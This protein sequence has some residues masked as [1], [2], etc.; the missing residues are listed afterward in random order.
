LRVGAIGLGVVTVI[1]DGIDQELKTQRRAPAIARHQT[2][3]ARQVAARAIPADREARRISAD[4]SSVRGDPAGGGV[5]VVG[6]G[7]KLVF[8]GEPVVHRDHDAAGFVGK[9]AA[10]RLMRVE[11]SRHPAAAVKPQQSRKRRLPLWRINAHR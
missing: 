1:R 2:N 11:A 8:R 4:R 7:R 9:L 6:R 3:G 5:A 10:A